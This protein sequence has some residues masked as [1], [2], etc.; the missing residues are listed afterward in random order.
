MAKFVNLTPHAISIQ[1]GE[2]LTSFPASGQLARVTTSVEVVGDH[3]GHPVVKTFY[4]DV[5]G[6]PP[7]CEGVVYIVSGMVLARVSGRRDVVG[8]DT[9]P[10]AIRNEKGQVTACTRFVC[11][12]W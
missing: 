6:L 3:D 11:N 5:E 7:P 9:G 1:T 12:D 2:S 4:G 10:T 8:P